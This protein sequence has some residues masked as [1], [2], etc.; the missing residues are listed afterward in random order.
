V[1]VVQ[2]DDH[3]Y[4]ARRSVPTWFDTSGETHTDS[5][6]TCLRPGARTA[7]FG[8]VDDA[9]SSGPDQPR[10]IVAVDCR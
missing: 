8:W 3:L 4:L 6:P 2:L 7:K 5:W 9:G 10:T 1:L